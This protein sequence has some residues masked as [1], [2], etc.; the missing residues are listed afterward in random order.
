MSRRAALRYRSLLVPIVLA[1]CVDLSSAEPT[2]VWEAEL[3]PEIANPDL[4][5]HVGAV[6]EA[7]GTGVGIGIV[8]AE[9]GAT[10]SWGL[11]EG[12]CDIPRTQVGP[13]EDYPQLQVDLSGS[14]S[15]ETH[16]GPRLHVGSSY[17]AQLRAADGSLLACGDLQTTG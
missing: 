14:A 8:G 9:P 4:T 7:T 1:A 17:H 5:G 16:L 12:T 15:A 6:S 2:S 11:H 13:A 3:Q 10:L